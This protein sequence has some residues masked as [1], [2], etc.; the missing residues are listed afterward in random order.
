MYIVLKKLFKKKFIFYFLEKNIFNKLKSVYAPIILGVFLLYI[1]RSFF[2]IWVRSAIYY[3]WFINGG[4]PL[5][6]R[7]VKGTSAFHS[8]WRTEFFEPNRCLLK[9]RFWF[10]LFFFWKLFLC[11]FVSTFVRYFVF[12]KIMKNFNN[13]LNF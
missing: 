8:I 7:Q 4:V 11:F 9:W 3:F 10:F 13:F 6:L 5:V 1:E 12:I 2:L